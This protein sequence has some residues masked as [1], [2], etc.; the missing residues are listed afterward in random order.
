MQF[1]TLHLLALAI[2]A[3]SANAQLSADAISASLSAPTS[4]SAA[5]AATG[6]AVDKVP[7]RSPIL[8]SSHP[9]SVY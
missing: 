1:K 3:Q 4:A 8:T 6:A 2:A 9:K 5:S 7:V